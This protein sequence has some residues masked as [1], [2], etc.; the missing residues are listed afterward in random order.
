MSY[1]DRVK[2]VT[3]YL[4]H[5]VSHGKGESSWRDIEDHFG[6]IPY[7]GANRT[8]YGEHAR[9]IWRR[10][11]KSNLSVSEYVETRLRLDSAAKKKKSGGG[12][13]KVTHATIANRRVV[14]NKKVMSTTDGGE[15]LIFDADIAPEGIRSLEDA[16]AFSNVD[17]DVWKPHDFRLKFW[18]TTMKINDEVVV[19]T[20]VGVQVYFKRKLG[21][22]KSY[23]TIFQR[24][25][26]ELVAMKL[27]EAKGSKTGVLSVADLHIGADIKHLVKGQDFDV[28][29]LVKKLNL[30]AA[31]INSFQY[32]HV[33]VNM[34]GDYFESITG[35]N[36]TDTWKSIGS[37]M[38]GGS[39]IINGVEII[40]AFLAKIN[41]LRGVNIV[42]GNHDRL[43]S[44]RDEDTEQSAAHIL[45][46][47]LGLKFPDLDIEYHADVISKDIDGICY[48]LTHG[49]LGI[50]KKDTSK[51][52]FRFGD[53]EKYTL[54]LSGHWH[55]RLTT[56]TRVTAVEKYDDIVTVSI[57]EMPYRKIL[58]PSLFTGNKWSERHGFSGTSGCIISENNGDGHP[59]VFDFTV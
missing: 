33:Y 3:E 7:Q 19:N 57:D 9:S 58:V 27:P 38:Y 31:R 8:R 42:S 6:L 23:D 46:W 30:V 51:V 10:F 14:E 48:L 22:G 43:S 13:R 15:T 20:N 16:V 21:A 35:M 18:D 12:A 28:K 25:H 32:K 53:S 34:L 59:N 11:S 47:G 50:N 55:S 52:I 29:I 4:L 45:A 40:A 1:E 24:M 5:M 36:H 37:G 56:R 44:R 41:N 2:R 54:W 26:D 39:L 49:H 17:L